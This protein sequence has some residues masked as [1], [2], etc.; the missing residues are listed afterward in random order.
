MPG[1]FKHLK[2][3]EFNDNWEWLLNCNYHVTLKL[4]VLW[5][6]ICGVKTLKSCHWWEKFLIIWNLRTW[7][8]KSWNWTTSNKTRIFFITWFTNLPTVIFRKVEKNLKLLFYFIHLLLIL[9]ISL[10]KIMH[11]WGSVCV[12]L[13]VT[14]LSDGHMQI[15]RKIMKYLKI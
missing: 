2:F 5:N 11:F 3:N 12:F 1:F 4:H 13:R 6:C 9:F 14:Q 7:K 10:K 8:N 15:F